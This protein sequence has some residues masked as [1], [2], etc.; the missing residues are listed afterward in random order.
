MALWA[1]LYNAMMNACFYVLLSIMYVCRCADTSIHTYIHTC[2][3]VHTKSALTAEVITECGP[4]TVN[5]VTN[6]KTTQQ[7]NYTVNDKKIGGTNVW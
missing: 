7:H 1:S 5:P 2:M 3:Y 4:T 6:T